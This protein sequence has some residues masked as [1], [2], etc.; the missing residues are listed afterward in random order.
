[1][2]KTIVVWVLRYARLEPAGSLNN[3]RLNVAISVSALDGYNIRARP[4]K[5]GRAV[6][7]QVWG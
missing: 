5:N 6:A 2:V 1:M 7:Q 3:I 4:R